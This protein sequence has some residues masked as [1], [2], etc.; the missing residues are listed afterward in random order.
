MHE[1]KCPDCGSLIRIDE[2]NY[3]T[4]LKQVRD[5]QFEE[6][7]QKRLTILENDKKKSVEI[8]IQNMRFQMKETLFKHEKK[9][10]VF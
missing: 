2:T 1:I 5:E 7:L 6:D 3:S 9:I 8:A 4:I 10:Q